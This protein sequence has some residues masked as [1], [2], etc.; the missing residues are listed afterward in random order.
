MTTRVKILTLIFF[1]TGLI[2]SAQNAPVSTAGMITNATTTPG[3]VIVPVTVTNFVSIGY[4]TLTLQ[5]RITKATYVSAAPNP[6]FP[7]MTVNHSISG[8]IGKLVIYWLETPGG[9]TLPDQAHLLDLTF[10][11]LAGTTPLSWG[12]NEG[13]VCEYKKYSNGN[14]ILLNDNPETSY[15]I[16]GGISNRGAPVTYAPAITCAVSGSTIDVPITVTGFNTIGSIY[17]NLDYDTTVLTYQ[18][19]TPNPAFGGSFLYSVAPATGVYK[20]ITVGFYGGNLSLAD[21]STIYSV[22][23][24]YYNTAGKGNYST[25][26]WFDDGPSCEYADAT[27]NGL[28]DF[29]YA[30]FYKT[31]LVYSQYAARAWLPVTTDVTPYSSHTI[32]VKTRDFSG[33][34]SFTLS[35]E[36]DTAALTYSGFT[37]YSTLAAGMTVTNNPPVG[38]KRKLVI[39]WTGAGPQTLP[40]NTS[41]VILDFTYKSGTTTLVWVTGDA[42]SC[43]FNDAIGNAYCDLPKSSFYQ[44]GLI[45][46]QVAPVTVAWYASPTVGQQVT[47]PVKVYDFE[48][49]GLFALTLDYDPGVLTYQS[50][51]LVPSIGGS[52]SSLTAGAGRILMN[53]TGTATSLADSTILINLTFTYNGGESVLAWHDDGNSCRYAASTTDYPLYDVPVTLYY[54]N[55]YVGQNPLIA[56]FTGTNLLPAVNETVTFT[57]ISAGNPTSWQWSISPSTFQFVNGT[58]ATSQNPQ[59]KFT[60]NGAY[61]VILKVYRGAF[62]GIKVRSDYIHAGTPGLWTGITSPDWA[63][64]SNW[65]NYMVPDGVCGVLIS[66]SAP[67]WPLVSGDLTIGGTHCDNLTMNG[68]SQLTI[69]GDIMINSGSALTVNASGMLILGGSWTNGGTFSCGTGTVEFTGTEDATIFDSGPTETFYKVIISKSAA[70]VIVQGDVEVIG[71]EGR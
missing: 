34:S 29:P 47:I 48:N 15:Y 42:T 11:Y 69:E 36:Y 21:G 63:V 24:T 51:S 35:F 71:V 13:L 54:I 32:P 14:Y 41:V 57:D 67:N 25:L 58:S 40:D 45:T 3:G 61:S 33:I 62:V 53:W 37:P 9:I 55:G 50:A 66:S 26:T 49:I 6:A 8:S 1:L 46:S 23:F 27:G 52:Y 68:A 65:N 59:V 30:D 38:A 20:R 4:F 39:G 18:S 60:T 43:R 16:N 44:D 10:T 17:L 12:Y 22:R 64:A 70:K 56:N 19:L 28:I 2:A 7:G 5:Y 31:G